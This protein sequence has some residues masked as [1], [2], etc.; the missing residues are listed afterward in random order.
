[1]I[2]RMNWGT[3]VR[4]VGGGKGGKKRFSREEERDLKKKRKF[5]KQVLRI[6]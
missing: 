2:A 5:D 6:A 1:M 4:K 3:H